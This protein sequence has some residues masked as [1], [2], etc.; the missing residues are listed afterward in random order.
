MSSTSYEKIPKD[1][2]SEAIQSI[3]ADA[4][5]SLVNADLFQKNHSI[6]FKKSSIIA[7][8]LKSAR[9]Y[10]ASAEIALDLL[11]LETSYLEKNPKPDS[12]TGLLLLN[13]I[14]GYGNKDEIEEMKKEIPKLP[15]ECR[16][17][18]YTGASLITAKRLEVQPEDS[19]HF[20]LD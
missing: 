19:K 8:Y 13:E 11:R 6:F 1:R 5:E 15:R 12:K 2:D 14:L 17:K 4:I 3:R 10:E 16:I 18:F 7:D 20:R 9:K